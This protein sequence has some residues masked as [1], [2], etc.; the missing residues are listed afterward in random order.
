MIS[1]LYSEK[2]YV[3]SR[4]FIK[5]ALTRPPIDLESEIKYYYL[6]SGKLRNAIDHAKRLLVE[7]QMVIA[8]SNIE[9]EGEDLWNGDGIGRLSLGAGLSLK[10]RISQLP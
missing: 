2:A 4:G 6:K 10:V 1:R 5:T 3:L 7:S 8:D 9:D